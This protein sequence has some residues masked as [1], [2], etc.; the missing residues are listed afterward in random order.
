MKMNPSIINIP[1]N[2]KLHTALRKVYKKI[3]LVGCFR[4]LI[5]RWVIFWHEQPS[6]K[7][8]SF[9]EL[10]Y[11]V[12]RYLRKSTFRE[13]NIESA[14]NEVIEQSSSQC[15]DSRYE[16]LFKML[17]NLYSTYSDLLDYTI[18][19]R[20]TNLPYFIFITY[21]L[22]QFESMHTV[23]FQEFTQKLIRVEYVTK[24]TSSGIFPS[25]DAE[26]KRDEG[27]DS[28][29]ILKEYEGW[30]EENRL[31]REAVVSKGR[32][33]EWDSDEEINNL[34]ILRANREGVVK[35]EESRVGVRTLGQVI[36][37]S[38]GEGRMFS[39]LKTEKPGFMS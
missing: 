35:Q 18:I 14:L 3:I 1:L 16:D 7:G 2:E 32:T 4:D 26:I 36:G 8:I 23:S 31:D 5:K 13:S 33:Y 11:N 27:E 10:N 30:I 39:V 29:S 19:K 25:I 15:P 20:V 21:F 22:S 28:V 38:E 34:R 17:R 6:L 9:H 12:F 37:G 24:D